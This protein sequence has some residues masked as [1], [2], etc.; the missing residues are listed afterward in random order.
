MSAI[1]CLLRPAYV[2]D[3]TDF[4]SEK[5]VFNEKTSSPCCAIGILG[6]ICTEIQ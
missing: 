5:R 2:V 3:W 4:A 1:D 6:I